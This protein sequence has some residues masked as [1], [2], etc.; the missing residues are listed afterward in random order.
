[1]KQKLIVCICSHVEFFYKDIFFIKYESLELFFKTIIFIW[2]VCLKEPCFG[3]GM[4]VF[5]ENQPVIN[6]QIPDVNEMHPSVLVLLRHIYEH[7]RNHLS[8]FR[9]AQNL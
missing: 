7:F 4:F 5:S 3:A 9:L 1:M 8:I 2:G 6:S